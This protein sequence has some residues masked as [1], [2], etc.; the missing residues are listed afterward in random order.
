MPTQYDE[1]IRAAVAQYLPDHDWRLLKAQYMAESRL[2]PNAVSPVGAR[3]IAQFMPAT[4]DEVSQELGYPSDASPFDADLAIP[5]GAY[6]MAKLL[7]SWSAPRPDLDRYCLA[8]A[9]YNAG[10]GHL[11]KAQKAAGGAN[12]YAS[13]IRALPQVTGHHAAETTAYVKRILNYFNQMV[14]G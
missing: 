3:G 1:L 10:F 13:I 4:W 8:L 12:D 2:D 5:A 9:S 14:T 7:N 11:L 6:Y